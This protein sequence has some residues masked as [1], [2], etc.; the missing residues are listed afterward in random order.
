LKQPDRYRPFK[1]THTNVWWTPFWSPLRR[2]RAQFDFEG[3]ILSSS[4]STF[5][6]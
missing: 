2:A 6:I 5:A 3:L 4:L 1:L